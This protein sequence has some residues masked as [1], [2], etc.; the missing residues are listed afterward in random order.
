VEVK[1]RFFL[2]LGTTWK[3]LLALHT[4]YIT[5]GESTSGRYPIERVTS[6]Y[7]IG[8]AVSP[9]AS[10]DAVSSGEEETVPL[11]GIESW[12]PSRLGV[13]SPLC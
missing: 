5:S 13:T 1:L 10:V 9:T 2:K 12:F 4:G 7:R 3:Y 11:P 6:V 8:N